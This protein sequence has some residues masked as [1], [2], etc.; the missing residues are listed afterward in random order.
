MTHAERV[1]RTGLRRGSTFRGWRQ[2]PSTGSSREPTRCASLPSVAHT[3]R[4]ERHMPRLLSDMAIRVVQDE[5]WERARD[6]RLR[7]LADAPDSF[8][9]SLEEE[10]RLSHSAW[11]ERWERWAPSDSRGWFVEATD[12]DEFVGMA[13]GVLDDP[14][15]TAYLFGMWVEPGRRRSGIGKRLVE[16]VIEWGRARGAVRIELEVNEL[17]R[18]AV[19]L[20]QACGFAPTGRSRPLP[21]NPSATALEMARKI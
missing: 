14:S 20:Y 11:K 21:S 13:V 12:D 4:P 15:K 16:A 3:D 9:S 6:L 1:S 7:A 8:G 10:E 17:T 18:P 19:A 2:L 5:E